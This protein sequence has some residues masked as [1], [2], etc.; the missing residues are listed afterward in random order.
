MNCALKIKRK[1]IKPIVPSDLLKIQILKLPKTSNTS[2]LCII[3]NKKE[4]LVL[5]NYLTVSNRKVQNN[6]EA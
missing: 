2:F 5:S 4:N 6:N 1:K 3:K